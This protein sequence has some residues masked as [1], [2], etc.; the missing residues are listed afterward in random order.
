VSLAV[1]SVKLGNQT[2]Q[3]QGSDVKDESGSSIGKFDQE[4]LTYSLDSKHGGATGKLTDIA[5]ATVTLSNGLT[6]AAKNLNQVD[7]LE[8]PPPGLV[9]LNQSSGQSAKASA[10]GLVTQATVQGVK[11]DVGPPDAYGHSPVTVEGKPW[12]TFKQWSGEYFSND[13]SIAGNIKDLKN[14]D[15]NVSICRAPAPKSVAA[16]F[17]KPTSSF[18]GQFEKLGAIATLVASTDIGRKAIDFVRA[19]DIKLAFSD[20]PGASWDSGTK[21]LTLSNSDSIAENALA[22]IHELNH[23]RAYFEGTTPQIA[24]FPNTKEGRAEYVKAM[25]NEEADGTVQSIKLLNELER[26]Y[27]WLK[28]DTPLAHEYNQAFSGAF[29][30]SQ[31]AFSSSSSQKRADPWASGEKAGRQVIQSTFQGGSSAVIDAAHGGSHAEHYGAQ[32]DAYKNSS[33][34]PPVLRPKLPASELKLKWSASSEEARQALIAARASYVPDVTRGV[35]VELSKHG[36]WDVNLKE[37]DMSGGTLD[38]QKDSNLGFGKNEEGKDSL[39]INVYDAESKG[40]ST[41]YIPFDLLPRKA[42]KNGNP[43]TYDASYSWLDDEGQQRYSVV[44][45]PYL[46]ANIRINGQVTSMD[47]QL[48]KFFQRLN[49]DPRPG[50]RA[51]L[52]NRGS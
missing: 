28:L 12:G 36:G 24:N 13:K 33:T 46:D 51:S 45:V 30:K 11:F 37:W 27:P 29:I 22:G 10:D 17:L 49:E 9:A 18:G 42:D 39:T 15:P 41:L 48:A 1:N 43:V 25:L 32:F 5:D 19:S 50:N 40:F 31:M 7:M 44:Q 14:L 21:T 2:F 52:G 16:N 6:V 38:L 3:I 47:E 26:S 8:Q 20:Q 34:T 35:N 4:Q 23:A